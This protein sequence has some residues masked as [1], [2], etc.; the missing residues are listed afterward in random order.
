MNGAVND[1]K[2][3]E[4]FFSLCVFMYGDM[5]FGHFSMQTEYLA[6]IIMIGLNESH[7]TVASRS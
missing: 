1:P 3:I 4:F 6:L 7:A 2:E 5:H